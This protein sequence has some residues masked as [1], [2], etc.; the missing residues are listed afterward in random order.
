MIARRPTDPVWGRSPRRSRLPLAAGVALLLASL[1]GCGLGTDRP[2]VVILLMDTMRPDHLGCYGYKRNTCPNVDALAARGIT[3]SRCYATADYTSASTASLLTGRYPLAHGYVN[4]DHVLDDENATLAEILQEQGYRTGGFTA[5]GLVGEKYQMQQGF[6]YFFEQ[7]RASA[8]TMVQEISAFVRSG[9]SGPYF[10]YAHF[11]DVHDPHRLPKAQQ[12]RFVDVEPFAY[13]MTD[14]LLQEQFIMGAWWASVQKWQA[15]SLPAARIER[16]FADYGRLYDAAIAYWDATLGSLLADL[17]GEDAERETIVV[18]TA[19]HGEQLLEHGFF[20]HANSGYDVGLHIPLVL[21][22]PQLA[23]GA[24]RSVEHPISIADVLP[25]LLARLDIE[26]PDAVQGR[27]RWSLVQ[28]PEGE[29][30]FG[31]AT[32]AAEGIYTAGTFMSNRPFDTLTQTYRLGAWKLILDRLRDSKELYN[33]ETDP[34]ERRD[35][36]AEEP[37]IASRLGEGLRRRYQQGLD[38]FLSRE[39]SVRQREAEKLRELRSLGYLS[40]GRQRRG[41]GAQFSPM[42]AVRLTRFGPFG[43]EPS[44][45]AFGDHLDFT[46]GRVVWGQVIRGYS[47]AESRADTSGSWF[48][49]RATFMLRNAQRRSRVIFEVDLVPD[50]AGKWPT[51]LEAEFNDR[52]EQRWEMARPGPHRLEVAVPAGL[53]ADEMFHCGLRANHRFVLKKGE[54]PRFDVFGSLKIRSV[55]MVE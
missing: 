53:A 10:V 17:A 18:I 23:E 47:D 8:E 34:A 25:T 36:L 22:D 6:D 49:C 35:L 30:R 28:T 41:P 43:D 54:S 2:N 21:Y 12:M 33:L 44:L 5:N 52:L 32:P 31:A 48:D 40:G 1:A 15:P 27:E 50:A 3:F 38:I 37:E 13:D 11:M 16:Y 7:N 26:I 9:G 45:A 24:P 20:G 19:D 42:Q 51:R 46:S 55:R 14:S 29:A 39:R 4:A